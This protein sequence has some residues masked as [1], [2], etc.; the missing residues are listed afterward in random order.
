MPVHSNELLRRS[1]VMSCIFTA[2]FLLTPTLHIIALQMS[3]LSILL[4]IADLVQ[5]QTY[6][7]AVHWRTVIPFFLNFLVFVILVL[8]VTGVSARNYVLHLIKSVIFGLCLLVTSSISLVI[9]LF[10]PVP[11]LPPL[12][13]KHRVGT[14]TFTLPVT[15]PPSSQIYK[16]R[17]L[18]PLTVQ[19]W[20]PLSSSSP[21]TLFFS[22]LPFL[23]RKL[24]TLWTSGDPDLQTEESLAL[25]TACAQSS[26]IRPSLLKHLALAT[27]NAEVIMR[28]YRRV[29]IVINECLCLVYVIC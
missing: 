26:S 1:A 10:A 14:S 5:S 7:P 16:D 25:L 12:S 23:G 11:T 27:S 29:V 18:Y 13:G 9:L 19:A 15:L 2:V 24:A 20:Y 21:P 3:A 28:T 22:S 4:I 17:Q 8:E 6:I